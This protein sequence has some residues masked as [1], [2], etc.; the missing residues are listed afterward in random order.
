MKDKSEDNKLALSVVIATYNR[1]DILRMALERLSKQTF[2]MSDF[3]V[4]L[5]DDGSTD[6]TD[7]MVEQMQHDLPFCLLYFCQQHLGPGA[8]H[9]RGVREARAQIILFLANDMLTI[10]KTLESHYHCHIENPQPY[11][12]VVGK[13]RES[14][15]MPQ[16]AFQKKWNPFRGE[17]LDG[18]DELVEFDFWIS[19]L[20]MK[21]DFF[22]KNGICLE[23][24]E[25]A[26]E[27]LELAHRLFK[28]GLKL[29]YCSEALTYHYHP[30]TIDSVI[31]RVYK[32]GKNFHMYEERVPHNL[33]QK[34]AK[35]LSK[36]LGWGG[37]LRVL[38]RDVI[39][40]SLFN[41]ITIPY[42]IVPLIHRAETNRLI[43]PFVGVMEKRVS[44]YYFR[45][46]ISDWRKQNR[47][48]C[49]QHH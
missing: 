9:N 42:L 33:A 36:K 31:K 5:V 21:R 3:E 8:A 40:L 11:I 10:P 45:K 32:T 19:N 17:E 49:Q 26:F 25:P 29:I 37:F 27:D 35:I 24:P 18:K 14:P 1:K 39:R 47:K 23:Y 16:T 38:I 43:E 2:P 48:R 41:C 15:D 4:V 12:A 13:L 46:G 6:G 30:Q 34:K 44:G 22:L 28:K 7:K 20:S